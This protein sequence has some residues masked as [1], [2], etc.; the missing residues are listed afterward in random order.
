MKPPSAGLGRTP[1][2]GLLLAAT[3]ITLLA[4][5]ALFGGKGVEASGR[6][7]LRAQM[8]GK[9]VK[10]LAEIDQTVATDDGLVVIEAMKMENELKSPIDGV[11]TEVP[12]AEG[13]AVETD[14]LLMVIE[15]IGRDE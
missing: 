6:Q 4:G 3:L 7:E 2:I 12:V 13:D 5:L 11:V 1:A 15:P 14:T 9:I 10:V 8:P